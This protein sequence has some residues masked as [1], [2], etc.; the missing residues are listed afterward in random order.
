MP[1]GSWFY[2]GMRDRHAPM[3]GFQR[4]D[5]PTFVV[6]DQIWIFRIARRALD[7]NSTSRSTVAESPKARSTLS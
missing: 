3:Y 4:M 6:R 1:I 2:S 7:C 5:R